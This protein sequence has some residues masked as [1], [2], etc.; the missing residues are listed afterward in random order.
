DITKAVVLAP[1][2]ILA[3][4]P[5]LEAGDAAGY[6]LDPAL[7]DHQ[8][9]RA[10]LQA[11]ALGHFGGGRRLAGLVVDYRN[12]AVG[13]PVEPVGAAVDAHALDP[14]LRLPLDRQHHA[15]F[16]LRAAHL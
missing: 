3:Q 5:V 2:G 7:L 6:A 16:T 1:L 14:H 4:R 9:E 15:S 13:Q 11:I 8:A 10:E 12:R